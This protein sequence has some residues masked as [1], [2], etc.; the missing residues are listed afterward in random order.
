MKVKSGGAKVNRPIEP[1]KFDALHHRLCAY[2]QAKDIF[3]EDCYA[4]ADDR[5]RLPIR[6][7]RSMP[8]FTICAHDVHSRTRSC[9]ARFPQAGIHRDSA[10]DF[11]PILRWTARIPKP[12]SCYIRKK[13]HSHRRHAYAGEIKKSIFTVMNFLLPQRGVMAIAILRQLRQGQGRR[14]GF[15]RLVR[16]R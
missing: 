15:L 10:P 6:S 13:A 16:H 14:G 11:T 9:H 2:L 12:L 4:G 7:S 1:G 3:V 8:A 5:Y